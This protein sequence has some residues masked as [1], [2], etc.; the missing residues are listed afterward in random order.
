MHYCLAWR[1][2]DLITQLPTPNLKQFDDVT[3]GEQFI[4]WLESDNSINDEIA[5][6][7]CKGL[8]KT[9][10]R[11]R[12]NASK[13]NIKLSCI[14]SDS[15]AKEVATLLCINEANRQIHCCKIKCYRNK[16]NCFN[17]R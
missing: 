17:Q 13:N 5:N 1:K 15:L 11:L 4:K 16:Q 14:I 10:E 8:E 3:G 6:T 12:L 7:I 2:M 9:T